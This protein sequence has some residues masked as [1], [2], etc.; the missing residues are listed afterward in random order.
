M[1]WIAFLI[2]FGFGVTLL[3]GT[4]W[5]SIMTTQIP[6]I[7]VSG[8]VIFRYFN[9]GPFSEKAVKITTAFVALAGFAFAAYL[10]WEWHRGVL[11]QCG[12]GGC[13]AA[14]YSPGGELFFGIRTTTVGLTGYT[15]V[16]LSLLLPGN[17]GR[18]ATAGLGTFGFATSMYLTGYS[19]TELNTTCQWCIGSATAMT[20]IFTLSFWRLVKTLQ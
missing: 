10:A 11:P 4:T 20:T 2:L 18:L 16:L 6:L 12:S 8:L 19:V 5:Q 1:P 9:P 14:Q 17:L 7:P 13:T 15:L 3:P